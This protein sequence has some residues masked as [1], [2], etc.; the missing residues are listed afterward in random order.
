[1]FVIT[2]KLTLINYYQ[3]NSMLYSDFWKKLLC[4]VPFLFGNTC[5]CHVSLSSLGMTVSQTFLACDVFWQF[6]RVLVMLYIML[7]TIIWQ[8]FFLYIVRL[9]LWGGLVKKTRDQ[10]PVASYQNCTINMRCMSSF[11]I[12]KLHLLTLTYCV[13]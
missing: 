1:M 8:V 12:T 3:L 6:W 4:N 5:G 2:I 13:L 7:S 11:S 9:E 10:V